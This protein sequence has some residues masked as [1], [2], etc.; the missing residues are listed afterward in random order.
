MPLLETEIQS[1]GGPCLR[2]RSRLVAVHTLDSK[3]SSLSATLC[4]LAWHDLS[5]SC[6]HWLTTYS[7][8][9]WGKQAEHIF[10]SA[11]AAVKKKKVYEK[12]GSYGVHPSTSLLLSLS[13]SQ[14]AHFPLAVP[15]GEQKLNVFNLDFLQ[16]PWLAISISLY[17]HLS[18]WSL[19]KAEVT[20][21]TEN[22][23][24]I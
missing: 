5:I 14:G 21:T 18:F 2:S 13:L 1:R 23:R 12:L 20:K 19:C 10:K 9:S 11:R 17:P 15:W 8:A 3:F 7:K 16:V 22:A 24:A 6:V 4:C